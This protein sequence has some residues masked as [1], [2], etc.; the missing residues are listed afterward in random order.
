MSDDVYIRAGDRAINIYRC[1][2]LYHAASARAEHV[3]TGDAD[4]DLLLSRNHRG[5]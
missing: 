2:Q 4:D 3:I 1:R 5:F